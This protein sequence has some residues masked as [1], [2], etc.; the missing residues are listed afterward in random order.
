MENEL[1]FSEE[2]ELNRYLFYSDLNDIN[3]FV[4]D[5]DKEYEY[6]TIFS[7]LFGE[8]YHISSIF[9]A[10]GKLGVKKAFNEYGE[11]DSNNPNKVNVFIVDGDF[12]RYIR[13]EEMI[14]NSHFIYLK[15]YNIENYFIDKEATLKFAKGKLHL[16]D[17][18]VQ[19][20][21][22]Y[23]EWR[24]K[25]VSQAQKLFLLYC[26]VQSKLPSEPNV[27][28]NEYLF[29]DEK[30]GFE[31]E[32]A[33]KKYRDSI[34]EKDSDIL[35]EVEVIKSK[36][37]QINGEDYYGL[38]CGKFLLTSLYVYLKGK[39]KGSFSREDLRW[40]LINEFDTG[41]LKYIKEQVDGICRK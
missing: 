12:D 17:L 14:E 22:K 29:I 38:I 24:E 39:C 41:S 4:E 40:T 6:E 34:L 21:V 26:A 1:F 35:L 16:R 31:K 36:Y 15:Y 18:E 33:Y 10:G 37:E 20:K 8:Q 19:Q 2:A 5:K 11:F 23:D 30:S 27:A 3:F 28:R 32:N 25:I 7:R 13:N 9:A